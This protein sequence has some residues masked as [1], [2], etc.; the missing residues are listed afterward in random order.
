MVD[1]FDEW[2]KSNG[3]VMDIIWGPDLEIREIPGEHVIIY[4]D[5][6]G[7]SIEIRKPIPKGEAVYLRADSE[8][9]DDLSP[10][11]E[12]IHKNLDKNK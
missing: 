1:L 8:N 6:V 9:V 3:G 12:L 4:R 5:N 10:I 7:N 11:I 2:K